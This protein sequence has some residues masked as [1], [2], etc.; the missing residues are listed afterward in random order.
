[1]FSVVLDTCV[2]YP[3]Y[4]RDTLLRIAS[5]RLY[6]A[7]WSEEILGELRRNLPQGLTP[8]Q[9][10]RLLHEIRRNFPN[11]IVTGHEPLI[12]A[13]SND[14]K[15][16]HVLAAAVRADAAGIVTFNLADFPREALDPYEIEALHPD[17][18]LLNQLDLA[19][20]QTIAVLREQVAGYERPSMTLG[21]L[22]SALGRSGCPD[23]ADQLRLHVLSGRMTDG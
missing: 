16:R 10:D 19:P 4:L 8:G 7:L 2:L 12:Y 15:D 22:A 11:A 20:G 23:F 14:P 1:M 17:E 9:A 3:S 18:F 21:D 5:A 13:M 6:R